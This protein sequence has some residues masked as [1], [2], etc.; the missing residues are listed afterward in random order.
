MVLIMMMVM[1]KVNYYYNYFTYF[2]SQIALQVQRRYLYLE[3]I[4]SGEDIRKQ[5]P[6][7]VKIFD[8]LTDD[9]TDI[10]FK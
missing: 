4:F 1:V 7:E 10:T 5:L 3:S 9:W 2:T 6:S 8:K